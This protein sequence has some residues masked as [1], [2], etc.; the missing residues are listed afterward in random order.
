MN[1]AVLEAT[2]TPVRPTAI[3][4][5]GVAP[6][7]LRRQW[8]IRDLL[9]M[10]RVEL[11]PG[12]RERQIIVRHLLDRWLRDPIARS[13]L[14]DV[15]R[16]T[17]GFCESPSGYRGDECHRRMRTALLEAFRRRELVVVG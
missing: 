17:T 3:P 1:T 14:A 5:V 12:E 11:R 7:P 2:G 10:R 15:L 6:R 13:V 8:R 4:D 16:H 9:L